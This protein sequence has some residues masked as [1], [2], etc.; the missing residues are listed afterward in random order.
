MFLAKPLAHGESDGVAF[1]WRADGTAYMLYVSASRADGAA[2]MYV[3]ASW[4]GW[5]GT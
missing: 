3:S 4:L 1:A 2:Y 5:T